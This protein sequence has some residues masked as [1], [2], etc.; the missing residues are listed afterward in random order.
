MASENEEEREEE[1]EEEEMKKKKKKKNGGCCD[2][3][4]EEEEEEKSVP[5]QSLNNDG[6]SSSYDAFSNGGSC[7]VVAVIVAVTVGDSN[8]IGHCESV[9]VTACGKKRRRT[10]RVG[11]AVTMVIGY[12]NIFVGGNYGN[13]SL[14]TLSHDEEMICVCASGVQQRRR[15]AE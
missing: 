8:A 11:A 4:D 12:E 13:Q 7:G 1:E 5:R 9:S 14:H 6:H 10:Y 15:N 3:D 2:D